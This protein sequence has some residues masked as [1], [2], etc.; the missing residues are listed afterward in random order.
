[1]TSVP[2][3]SEKP[4]AT[5]AEHGDEVREPD[6]AEPAGD[7]G[8]P[9]ETHVVVEDA[10]LEERASPSV[11]QIEPLEAA[12]VS[13]SDAPVEDVHASET[14]GQSV[15][16][17]DTPA[18]VAAPE[19]PETSK[20]AEELKEAAPPELAQEERGAEPAV[21][22]HAPRDSSVALVANADEALSEPAPAEPAVAE[23]ETLLKV[24]DSA[25]ATGSALQ[26]EGKTEDLASKR[27]DVP[28]VQSETTETGTDALPLSLKDDAPAAEPFEKAN[29]VTDESLPPV[30]PPEPVE[31][32]TLSTPEVAD[33]P[34]KSHE[35]VLEVT[36]AQAALPEPEPPPPASEDQIWSRPEDHAPQPPPEPQPAA[37]HTEAEARADLVLWRHQEAAEDALSVA[38]P[39]PSPA[40]VL[41]A[42][43]PAAAVVLQPSAAT[44]T[45]QP[46][47]RFGPLRYLRLALR[48]AVFG[49][50][51]YSL[52]VLVLLVAYRWVDP[53]F[54]NLMLTQRLMGWQVEQRWVPLTQVSPNLVQAVILSEDGGFC[55]HQGVDWVAIEE[56][57]E[58]S[59]GGST[60]T[61]QVV[62]NLFLWS[63]RSYIR[64]AIEIP[65]A[66]L[67]EMLWSKQRIL[68]VYMNIAEWGDGVFGA[69]A[70]AQHHFR[71]RAG[72]LS[73]QEAALLAVSL[74]NPIERQAGDPGAQTRRLANNLMARMKAVR[75]SMTCVRSARFAW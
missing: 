73:A 53:P 41:H 57:I 58:E 15:P 16:P 6:S 22:D 17:P 30:P 44:T 54:S 56:A 71:K 75:T 35:E 72:Q 14:D 63:S 18:M 39:Q 23:E 52:L 13:D 4:A 45:H 65:L 34:P 12:R 28:E 20:R 55:R 66:L 50:I 67:M 26:V 19:P 74:P 5:P 32:F 10:A 9:E 27:H 11:A 48:A 69:E 43:A 59:R 36:P 70:A 64:K 33:A 46:A 7:D 25:P 51:G 1:V 40:G 38:A 61:M 24:A 21:P 3:S 49:L 60:I 68:E 8:V 62:K 2:A 47:A 31:D 42:A 29:S 37:Q